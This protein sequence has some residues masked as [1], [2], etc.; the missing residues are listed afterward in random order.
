MFV[1]FNFAQ[2]A[3]RIG[4]R[5]VLLQAAFIAIVAGLATA[6]SRI[7]AGV[8]VG[9]VSTPAAGH[10]VAQRVIVPAPSDTEWAFLVSLPSTYDPN[11]TTL[12]PTIVWYGPLCDMYSG[13]SGNISIFF[14]ANFDNGGPAKYMQDS[15]RSRYSYIADRFIVISPFINFDVYKSA[16]GQPQRLKGLHNYL[17]ATYK[18]DPNRITL[19]GGCAGGGVIWNYAESDPAFAASMVP[20]SCNDTWAST[21]N[22]A[23]S[24]TLKNIWIR[25]YADQNDPMVPYANQVAMH[26]ALDNCALLPRRDTLIT[27]HVNTHEIWSVANIL[28]TQAVYDW[29]LGKVGATAVAPAPKMVGSSKPK[30][31]FNFCSRLAHS[32]LLEVTSVTGQLILKQNGNGLTAGQMMPTLNRGM[33]LVRIISAHQVIARIVIAQ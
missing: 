24:C 9:G 32:D 1:P 8:T 10:Q 33:Y 13:G 5:W 2:K 16:G 29:M 25:H 22:V 27:T 18:I 6:S 26:T 11:G 3:F 4:L 7:P 23:N 14:T 17:K 30:E 31:S 20:I 15:I 21:V 28:N 12:W 19:V